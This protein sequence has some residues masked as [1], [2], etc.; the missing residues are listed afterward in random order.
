MQQWGECGCA[1]GEGKCDEL[2]TNHVKGC[3]TKG[4]KI[5]YGW[6]SSLKH[7]F[8]AFTNPRVMKGIVDVFCW[9]RYQACSDE[10]F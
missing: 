2:F 10:E 4:T 6:K 8:N 1:T 7:S 5:K 9:P 3:K